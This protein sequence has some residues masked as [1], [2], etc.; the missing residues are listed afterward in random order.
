MK[1]TI[2]I[3]GIAVLMLVLLIFLLVSKRKNREHKYWN[4]FIDRI[5][6]F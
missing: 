3:I 5:K 6:F 4:Q 2:V 1:K